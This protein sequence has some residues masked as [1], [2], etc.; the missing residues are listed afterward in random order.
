MS[1][2]RNKTA[3]AFATASSAKEAWPANVDVV[4]VGFGCAGACAALEAADTGANVV[5]LE[6][7]QVGA[8]S[9]ARSGGVLYFGGGTPI[10][11]EAHQHDTEQNMFAYL[12]EQCCSSGDVSEETVRAFVEGSRS[13]LVSREESGARRGARRA[14]VVP[15]VGVCDRRKQD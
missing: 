4:V 3:N 1:I 5:I 2:F 12:K 8:C 7:F 9:T 13:N 11:E 6:R 15:R 10:Q 14:G